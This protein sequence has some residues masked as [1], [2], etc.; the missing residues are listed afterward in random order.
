MGIKDLE[1]D[2]Q[3]KDESQERVG[4]VQEKDVER[5]EIK[6]RR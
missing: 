5:Y 6:V 4:G 1:T 2:S 3:T